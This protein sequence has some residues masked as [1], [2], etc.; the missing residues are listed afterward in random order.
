MADP[1]ANDEGSNSLKRGFA[2]E[3]P[4]PATS[5]LSSEDNNAN[6]ARKSDVNMGIS[7]VTEPAS[8]RV[9]V[10]LHEGKTQGD[11]APS[12]GANGSSKLE[13]PST[14]ESTPRVRGLAP[15]KSE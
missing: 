11:S 15:I 2:G 9:K 6:I 1:A 10:E 13:S 3:E 14:V 5:L 8:K 4:E 7:E 12:P